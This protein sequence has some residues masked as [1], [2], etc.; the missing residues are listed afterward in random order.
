MKGRGRERWKDEE[1][2]GLISRKPTRRDGFKKTRRLFLFSRR[3]SNAEVAE[4]ACRYRTYKKTSIGQ[5]KLMV[6][7]EERR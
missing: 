7:G 3:E 5:E 1:D 6:M 4:M 2:R